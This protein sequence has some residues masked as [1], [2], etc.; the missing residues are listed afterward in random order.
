MREQLCNILAAAL[1][2]SRPGEPRP[3]RTYEPLAWL[4]Q[5]DVGHRKLR[6]ARRLLYRELVDDLA[7]EFEAIYFERI[8][9]SNGP[10]D[11]PQVYI[12]SQQARRS[13]WRMRWCAFQHLLHV[14][15][16]GVRSSDAYSTALELLTS[17]ANT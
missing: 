14:P 13:I 10:W 3:A 17:C 15:G 6:R 9:A 1:E 7:A 11:F 16:A 2:S 12:A 4:L 5:E 8:A